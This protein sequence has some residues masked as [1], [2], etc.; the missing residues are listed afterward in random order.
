MKTNTKQATG[1]GQNG[2]PSKVHTIPR[3][4]ICVQQRQFCSHLKNKSL[5]ISIQQQIK[6]LQT[7]ELARTIQ[8]IFSVQITDW[9]SK[10]FPTEIVW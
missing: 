2:E 4:K 8:A 5:Q 3:T 9:N 1:I 6:K 7:N 10:Y